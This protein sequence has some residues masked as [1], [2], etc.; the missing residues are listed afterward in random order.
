MARKHHITLRVY[1]SKFKGYVDRYSLYI[2]TPRNLKAEWGYDGIGIGFSWSQVHD[3]LIRCDHFE[4]P[5]FSQ[6]NL[7]RKV[8]RETLPAF[9]QKWINKMEKLYNDALNLDTDAAWKKWEIA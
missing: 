7:G 4:C 6:M 3:S 9:V 1:D 2:P 5:H 8:K